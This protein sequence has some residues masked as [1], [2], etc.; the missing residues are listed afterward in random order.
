[1]RFRLFPL[2]LEL[3]LG[4][5]A[6]IRD[7]ARQER[8]R[9][10]VIERVAL[11]LAKGTFIPMQTEPSEI[12]EDHLLRFARRARDIGVLDAK[13]EDPLVALREKPV[14]DRSACAAD[15]EVPGGRGREAD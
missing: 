7:A 13:N 9:D 2:G 6:A 8:A 4:A 14:E 10:L 5:I 1:L 11:R 3:L 12:I 15:V